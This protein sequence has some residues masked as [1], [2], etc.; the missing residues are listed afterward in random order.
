MASRSSEPELGKGS[1]TLA[2]GSTAASTGSVA[3]AERMRPRCSR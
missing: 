3:L 1:D 2:L